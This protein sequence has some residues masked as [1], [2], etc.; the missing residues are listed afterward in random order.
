MGK[1]RNPVV[2]GAV[3]I[4]FLIAGFSVM[5][6]SQDKKPQVGNKELCSVMLGQGQEA[7]QKGLY[8]KAGYYFLQAVDADPVG[9]ATVWYGNSLK[10]QPEDKGAVEPVSEKAKPVPPVSPA[11]AS[12][13]TDAGVKPTV[14]KVIIGDDEGC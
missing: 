10:I 9:M 13:A 6:L 3:L 1:I 8:E 7:Y 11:T 4:A 14:P 2:F 12:P 5:S